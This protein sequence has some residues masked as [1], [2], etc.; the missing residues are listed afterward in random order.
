MH[1]V[2]GSDF[3]V[4]WWH[5]CPRAQGG[6]ALL[7]PLVTQEVR[8]LL[9]CPACGSLQSIIRGEPLGQNAAWCGNPD[10]GFVPLKQAAAVVFRPVV[11]HVCA[12]PALSTHL[13]CAVSVLHG[14][15]RP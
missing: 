9:C 11:L 12:Y 5:L 1:S 14:S 10:D 7:D 6:S 2:R 4:R 8:L 3:Q 15:A 13:S